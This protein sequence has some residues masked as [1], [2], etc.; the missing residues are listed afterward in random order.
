MH[1]SEKAKRGLGMRLLHAILAS[2]L[3]LILNNNIM[4]RAQIFLNIVLKS[5]I[6][7]GKM[8]KLHS[9]EMNESGGPEWH[10]Q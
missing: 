10:D 8:H 3:T 1:T 5:Y 4:F 9:N 7:I 2:K 6:K